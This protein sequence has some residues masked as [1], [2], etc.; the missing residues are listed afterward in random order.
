MRQ[1]IRHFITAL[2]FLAFGTLAN[3]AVDYGYTYSP[4]FP[5]EVT[6]E[7][8]PYAIPCAK[9]KNQYGA[10]FYRCTWKVLPR[11]IKV[12][13]AAQRQN[14]TYNNQL[15]GLCRR[16]KCIVQGA[17]GVFGLI[18]QDINFT[19]SR[20]YYIYPSSDGFPIAYRMDGGPYQNGKPVSYAQARGLLSEFLLDHGQLE[21]IVKD[22]LAA[23]TLDSDTKQSATAPKSKTSV[24]EAWCNPQMDDDCHI[25]KNKV[26]KADLNQFLPTVKVDDVESAGGYCEYPICYDKND[27]PIG[28]H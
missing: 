6:M 15:S 7:G 13:D 18:D 16:G 5:S 26:A 24:S 8:L 9:A 28:I 23:Y 10:E 27:K 25:N 17:D 3:A 21:S 12:Y 19:A 4:M 2:P 1:L 14:I 11:L 22:D 20:H